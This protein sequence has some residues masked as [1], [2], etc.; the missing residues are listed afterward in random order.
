[1]GGV[2]TYTPFCHCFRVDGGGGG[3]RYFSSVCTL[4]NFFPAGLKNAIL[5]MEIHSIL[6]ALSNEMELGEIRFIR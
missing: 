1:V 3:V 2:C 5:K 4:T 6:K